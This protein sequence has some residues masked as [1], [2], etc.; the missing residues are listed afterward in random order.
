MFHAHCPAKINLCL[1]L[2]SKRPDGYH[3]LES[4]FALLDIA[5]ELTVDCSQSALQLDISGPY[6]A[7]IDPKNNLLTQILDY[8]HTHFQISKNLHVSLTKNIPV[9]AGL[10]G[11][12]SNAAFFMTALNTLFSLNL[13]KERLQEISLHF[14]SDIAFFFEGKACIVKGRGEVIEP[15]PAFQPIAALLVNPNIHLSTKDI[16]ARF[17]GNFSAEIATST[18]LQKDVLELV[19]E[20]PNDTEKTAI[21]N[22][23]IIGDMLQD[24]LNQH[25]DIAKMS[26]TG[27]TCFAI[28]KDEDALE[29][30]A[31]NL[32]QKYPDFLIRKTKI[33]SHV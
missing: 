28:F 31:R 32:R 29:M 30:A 7:Y 23:P 6:A 2:L 24:M 5:D 16:F 14:G 15:F 3:A 1:K 19:R 8:F 26:G 27:S 18:L 33:M 11:G 10:G 13:S 4:L 25:A 21:A 17:D 22:A 12:S 9:G 20:L